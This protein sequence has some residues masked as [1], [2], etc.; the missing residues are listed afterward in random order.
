ME[1]WLCNRGGGIFYC[2]YPFELIPAI[3]SWDISLLATDIDADALS[4][5]QKGE[6]KNG[7]SGVFL[8]I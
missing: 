2:N 8:R 5:A 6:F 7:H 1:R 4:K 3:A